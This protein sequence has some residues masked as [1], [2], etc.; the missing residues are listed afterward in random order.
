MRFCKGSFAAL[1][2]TDQVLILI[3]SF[4]KG[5]FDF[6]LAF[7]YVIARAV[8]GAHNRDLIS[9]NDPDNPGES[10]AGGTPFSYIN[11]GIE[12]HPFQEV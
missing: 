8:R 2:M 12:R 11:V 4:P 3:Q 6:E 10:F 1:R 7:C 5:W 9:S